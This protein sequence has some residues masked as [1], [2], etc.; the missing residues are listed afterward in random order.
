MSD[1]HHQDHDHH[2]HDH[3]HHSHHSHRPLGMLVLGGFVA[4]G[5]IGGGCVLAKGLRDMKLADRSVTVRGV[6][7]Q[8]VKADLVLWNLKFAA[9]GDDL[10]LT[11]NDVEQQKTKLF[12]FLAAGG[13]KPEE[14]W[15]SGIDLTD[16][17]AQDY[18]DA[19]D[20]KRYTI[21]GRVVVRTTN[22]AAV[23]ALSRKTGDLI[24][25]GVALSDTAYCGSAPSYSFTKLNDVK[26][27][28][29]ADAM[30]SA[31]KAAEQFAQDSQSQVGKIKQA[32]Q[33]YFSIVER[34]NVDV[35]SADQGGNCAIS[36]PDKKVRVV[37]TIDYA[38]D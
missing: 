10:A 13:L 23:D 16:R 24:K 6:A 30:A 3:H 33:G 28:M 12:E 20:K 27:Q 31:R 5:L 7:E 32:T 35:G 11:Q 8:D 26:P 21:N 29:L 15:L 38:L 9:I 17:Q 1:H 36:S 14:M 4:L 25:A 37:T 34:D 19:K 22:V 18:G 2:A